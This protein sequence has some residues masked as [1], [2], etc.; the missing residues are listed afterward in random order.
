MENEEIMR[1]KDVIERQRKEAAKDT[2]ERREA[3]FLKEYRAKRKVV[4]KELERT[5][6]IEDREDAESRKRKKVKTAPK[7]VTR[8]PGDQDTAT[9]EAKRRDAERIERNR[10]IEKIAAE[11]AAESK[12]QAAARFAET[13]RKV[14]GIG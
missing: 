7:I 9:T 12:E 4:N 14:R 6:K 3:E 11:R 8:K 10:R 1:L 13:M 2:Q 5:R